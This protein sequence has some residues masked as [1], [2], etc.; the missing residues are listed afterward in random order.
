MLL[1]PAP[2]PPFRVVSSR[3]GENNKV[4]TTATA[5]LTPP[6]RLG[7]SRVS[8]ARLKLDKVVNFWRRESAAKLQSFTHYLFGSLLKGVL[9]F[10]V[11][12]LC[13]SVLCANLLPFRL[14]LERAPESDPEQATAIWKSCNLTGRNLEWTQA[15]IRDPYIKSDMWIIVPAEH[16]IPPR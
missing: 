15:H 3:R 9:L 7:V 4:A 11:Q 2:H 16:S 1:H 10:F 8:V 5:P 12:N 6:R 14:C 13:Q